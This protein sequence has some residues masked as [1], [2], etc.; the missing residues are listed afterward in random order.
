MSSFSSCKSKSN[1]VKELVQGKKGGAELSIGRKPR[2][3]KYRNLK[4]SSL[5]PGGVQ[6]L[7]GTLGRLWSSNIR[8]TSKK[9]ACDA[10]RHV[11]RLVRGEELAR[12]CSG[13]ALIF[14]DYGKRGQWMFCSPL[15]REIR[16][17]T[18]GRISGGG[19]LTVMQTSICSTFEMS[20][21]KQLFITLHWQLNQIT[22][23]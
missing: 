20:N 5:N 21:V 19:F 10:D 15:S 17:E 8:A 16:E 6:G 18:R 1:Y 11:C 3:I 23:K 9:G 22:V 12:R 2:R 14:P 7:V 13:G 4:D